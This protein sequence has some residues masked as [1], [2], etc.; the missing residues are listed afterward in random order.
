MKSFDQLSTFCTNVS[1]MTQS[2]GKVVELQEAGILA[3]AKNEI[4]AQLKAFK[5]GQLK[6]IMK[7]FMEAQLSDFVE[8][9]F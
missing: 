6:E 7:E 9:K 5:E 4:S 2:I 8:N 3:K 1:S